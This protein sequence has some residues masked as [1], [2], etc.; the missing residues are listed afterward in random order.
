MM[1]NC[2]ERRSPTQHKFHGHDVEA[3][4]HFLVWHHRFLAGTYEMAGLSKRSR[5]GAQNDSEKHKTQPKSGEISPPAYTATTTPAKLLL[6]Y[7]NHEKPPLHRQPRHV[8]QGPRR[9]PRGHQTRLHP[10][11]HCRSHHDHPLHPRDQG[12]LLLPAQNQ[13]G[14]RLQRRFPN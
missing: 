3:Q 8:P 13:S 11:H 4:S 10:L 6:H 2:A 1:W 5:S 9:S 14:I 12:I 7:C